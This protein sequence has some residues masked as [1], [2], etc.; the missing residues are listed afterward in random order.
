MVVFAQSAHLASLKQIQET[1]PAAM[2]A[3]VTQPLL[4]LLLLAPSFVVRYMDIS[5]VKERWPNIVVSVCSLQSSNKNYSYI[6]L[7]IYTFPS[8]RYRKNLLTGK[9]N[10]DTYQYKVRSQHIKHHSHISI[11]M[12][13]SLYPPKQTQSTQVYF[14]NL[15]SILP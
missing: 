2:Y 3:R 4:T 13:W 12:R 7:S 11:T 14:L 9:Q 6:F 5:Q 10:C 8:S 1:Q 15:F